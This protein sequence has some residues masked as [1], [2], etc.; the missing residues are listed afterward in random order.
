MLATQSPCENENYI[1]NLMDYVNKYIYKN[2]NN[3][4]IV[5]VQVSRTHSQTL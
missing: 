1:C 4:F 5:I 3:P 2:I